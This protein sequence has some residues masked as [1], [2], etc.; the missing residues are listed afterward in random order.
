[1]L[2]GRE[3]SEQQIAIAGDFHYY[4]YACVCVCVCACA[5]DALVRS[6]ARDTHSAT[7]RDKTDKRRVR[8]RVR[9]TLR[10]ASPAGLTRLLVRR[11]A[12]SSHD[13]R[14]IVA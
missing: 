6:V 4:N 13:R 12:R 10:A 2:T 1:M 3:L 14:M 7:T 9:A 11:C 5:F 8:P